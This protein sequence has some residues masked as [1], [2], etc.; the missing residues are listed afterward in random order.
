MRVL[1]VTM[2]HHPQDARILHRQIRALVEAGHAITHIAPWHDSAEP[3]A[4]IETVAIPRARGRRRMAALRAARAAVTH[5]RA[6][7]DIVVVHD[8][9]VV[10]AL[11][12]L[13]LPPVVW[14]VHEDTAAALADKPWLPS[15]LRPGVR[16]AVRAGERL[17]EHTI[18]LLLAEPGYQNRFTRAHPVV[19]NEPY[20]PDRHEPPGD[21]R[22]VCLGRISAGRGG[23]ELIALAELL[24]AGVAL[25]LIGSADADVEAELAAAHRAGALW[26]HGLVPNDRA[27]ALVDGAMA[28]LS[29]LADEANY[30]HSRPTKVV[31][32]MARGVP[33]ITTPTPLAA[34]AVTAHRCGLVVPFASPAAAARALAWLADHPTE[35]RAMGT[36]GHAAASAHYNWHVSGQKFVAQLE[37]WAHRQP[38]ADNP[39]RGLDE[40][41]TTGPQTTGPVP[42]P[43]RRFPASATVTEMMD[44]DR[45]ER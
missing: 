18:H 8:P 32:Y 5:H 42:P 41:R 7:S 9:E 45:G 43:P 34:E 33:V 39:Q 26:W 29:L 25:E 36:R 10:A 4:D 40:G 22:V 31:E 3:P 44:E 23:R 19:A 37:A 14:D 12:G 21:Q 16:L 30:R 2:V 1:V 17:A 6:A 38:G 20:V 11:A 28:G 24:P 13:R 27:L 15:S 35:R